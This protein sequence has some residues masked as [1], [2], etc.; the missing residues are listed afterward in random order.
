MAIVASFLV[1]Y[2]L[3]DISRTGLCEDSDQIFSVLPTHDGLSRSG[4]SHKPSP[5][6]DNCFC[7]SLTIEPN[8][9][10]KV[11][12]PQTASRMFIDPA[13]HN[14]PVFASSIYHPPKAA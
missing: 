7:C 1:F 8:Q 4:V 6:A 13:I 11:N 12:D 3:A 10:F 14:T 5:L 2:V 9:R